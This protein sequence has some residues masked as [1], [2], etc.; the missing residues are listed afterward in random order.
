MLRRALHAR[1]FRYRLHSKMLHGRPD[2]IFPKYNAAVF[3]HG[4]FW[5]RHFGCR[6]STMPKTRTAFWEKKFADNTI[7]DESVKDQ[8]L[9]SGWRVAIVWEC[10]LRK[11]AE[12]EEVATSLCNWLT[13]GPTVLELGEPL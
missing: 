2:L 11:P 4:C 13:S 8:L 12:A 3:V 9:Q 5:H 7:R 1:G 6:Y 10:A